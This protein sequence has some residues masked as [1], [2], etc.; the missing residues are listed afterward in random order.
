MLFPRGAYCKEMELGRQSGKLKASCYTQQFPDGP[1][2]HRKTLD[3]EEGGRGRGGE[4][5]EEGEEEGRECVCVWLFL[6][7]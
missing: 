3:R 5:E 6:S 7:K 1:R 4:G 2:Q